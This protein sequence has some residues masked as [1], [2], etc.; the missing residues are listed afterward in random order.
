MDVE[1]LDELPMVSCGTVG[2]L[3]GIDSSNGV[4]LGNSSKNKNIRGLAEFLH[5][6]TQQHLPQPITPKKEKA[7]R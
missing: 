3:S 4:V 7:A 5:M 1:V 2:A 6:Q